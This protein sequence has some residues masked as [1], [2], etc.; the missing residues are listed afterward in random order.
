[1]CGS[2]KGSSHLSKLTL[3]LPIYQNTPM[4]PDCFDN[5]E[6]SLQN[7]RISNLA[8]KPES[9]SL[10]IQLKTQDRYYTL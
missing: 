5:R 8:V 10:T 9:L 4:W 7:P 2:F 1:M 3:A 6:L